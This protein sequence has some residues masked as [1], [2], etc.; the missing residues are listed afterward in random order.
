MQVHKKVVNEGEEKNILIKLFLFS[1]FIFH[2]CSTYFGTNFQIKFTGSQ[3]IEP[4][5]IL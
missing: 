1:F 3:A 4:H 2:I 5:P